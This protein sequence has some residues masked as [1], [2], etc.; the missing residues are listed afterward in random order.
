M[1]LTAQQV[2]GVWLDVSIGQHPVATVFAAILPY[3]N[4]AC[5]Y[6]DASLF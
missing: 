5:K 6:R 4:P 1:D 3:R 2:A